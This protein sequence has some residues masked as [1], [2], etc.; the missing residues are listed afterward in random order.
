MTHTP[1]AIS[2]KNVTVVLGGR[3]I[4]SDASLDIPSCRITALIGPNGAGKTTLLR[5][6]LGLIP[7]SGSITFPRQNG[8]KPRIGYIPQSIEIERENP[9]RVVEFLVLNMQRRPLWLGVT[10][11]LKDRTIEAL[12]QTGVELLA[13]R[14]VGKLSG[15]EMQRVL[16]AK[17][18]L[19]SPDIVLMDEPV[20]GIDIGGESLFCELLDNL[21]EKQCF[22]LVLVSH[23]L[24]LV[25]HHA[26][27]VVCLNRRIKCVGHTADMLTPENLQSLFGEKS[28]L[29]RHDEH[30]VGHGHSPR[31]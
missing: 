20:S 30:F 31:L 7:Y 8:V 19:E 21:H 2:I 22:T 1:V 12:R 10:K 15:G 14:P 13:N 3:E 24:S 29:V 25:A 27:N 23:D 26:V 9:I 17:I 11:N 28:A 18:L 5:A 6:I 16:L 4:V